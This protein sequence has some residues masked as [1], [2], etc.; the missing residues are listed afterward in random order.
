M[1]ENGALC[2]AL[3]LFLACI[4]MSCEGTITA[5]TSLTSQTPTFQVSQG[6]VCLYEWSGDDHCAGPRQ[7]DQIETGPTT[8]ADRIGPDRTGPDR[9]P[10]RIDPAECIPCNMPVG[11]DWQLPQSGQTGPTALGYPASLP[12]VQKPGLAGFRGATSITTGS[13]S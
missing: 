8:E 4:D 2:V 10:K 13:L 6:C 5:R 7:P 1:V 9:R 12:P 11:P 3:W